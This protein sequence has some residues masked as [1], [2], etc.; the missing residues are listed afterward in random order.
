MFVCQV[1]GDFVNELCVSMRVSYRIFKNEMLT[2][3]FSCFR[4]N[5]IENIMQ[6]IL[7]TSAL[8]R[9]GTAPWIGQ[10]WA[11]C[12]VTGGGKGSLCGNGR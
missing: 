10:R 4:L 6:K 7:G 11:W 3:F 8:N 9:D 2:E 5:Q 1:Y 12:R